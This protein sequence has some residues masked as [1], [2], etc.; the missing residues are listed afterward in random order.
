MS[1]EAIRSLDGEAFVTSP[2]RSRSFGDVLRR[3]L[4]LARS[5]HHQC[6]SGAESAVLRK[7]FGR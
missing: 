4:N 5:Q 7:P 1:G 6:G 3:S 2:M